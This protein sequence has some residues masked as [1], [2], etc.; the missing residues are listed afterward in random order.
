MCRGLNIFYKKSIAMRHIKTLTAT[1]NY[2]YLNLLFS[3]VAAKMWV[4]ELIKNF[5]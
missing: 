4:I 5:F 1:T 2:C 3:F